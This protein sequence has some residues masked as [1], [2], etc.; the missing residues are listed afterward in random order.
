[1]STIDLV[2]QW[3][4]AEQH[5]DAAA[6]D[7]V[8]AADFVG[9]GPFGF[10]LDRDQWLA[11]FGQG[12]ENHAVT[13]AEPQVHEHDGSAV[14]IGVLDQQTSHQGRDTSGRFRVTIVAVGD[15]AAQ[16]VAAVHIGPL[17]DPRSGPPDLSK[18]RPA[19]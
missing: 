4:A 17:H 15:G 6:L 10:V 9:V 11:R 8:L 14:V 1:M 7:Q 12:L 5:N 13:V 19:A 18:L 2:Q 16:R 3:A